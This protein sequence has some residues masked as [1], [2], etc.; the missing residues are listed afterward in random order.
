MTHD[1]QR[2]L[3]LNCG[4]SSLKFALLSP[5]GTHTWL[6]GLAECLGMNNA[7]VTFKQAGEKT[8][9]SLPNGGH[10]QAIALLIE[11]LETLG[12]KDSVVAIGHRVVHGGERFDRPEL[13]TPDV[14]AEIEALC[15]LAPLHNPSNLL[16]IQAAK[17]AF[18]GLPQVVVFDTAFH[19]TMAP[20][21]YRYAIPPRFYTEYGV[22]R[23]G[24]HG[25]SH[26]YVAQQAVELLGLDPHDHNILI[27][28][29]GNGA[30]ATAVQN[31]RSVDTTMGMTPLEGLVMGTRSGDIDP[32]A[33]FHIARQTG[34]SI[35]ELDD[36]LNKQSGLKGM[37]DLSSDY[38]DVRDA[39]AEGNPDAQLALGV[40]V[41]R[42]ARLLGGLATNLP[43]VDALIFTGGIGENAPTLRAATVKRLAILNFDIDAARNDATVLGQAGVIS[44][45][46]A[47]GPRVAV[48]PTNEELMI[49]RSTA[50]LTR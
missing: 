44:P 7:S 23:Y 40:T 20:A 50:A 1:I 4:S 30:S 12:W 21:V 33:L 31:G 10:E 16:G 45:A 13:V 18:P 2:I 5:E 34:M 27:A 32:G 22:R 48:I 38:R 26:D 49:A 47:N 9:C 39:A 41:H 11:H 14:E 24:A 43:R 6:S 3:V 29:L 37:T 17:R 28:H 8:T 46:E 35:N 19:Q 15:S 25:T 42:L 36:L